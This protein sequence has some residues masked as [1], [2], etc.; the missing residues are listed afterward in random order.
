MPHLKINWLHLPFGFHYWNK[1]FHNNI[2]QKTNKVVMLEYIKNI[3]CYFCSLFRKFPQP[4]SKSLNHTGDYAVL[5]TSLARNIQ[6]V[7]SA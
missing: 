6:D 7:F 2:R 1:I 5:I 3:V 4:E